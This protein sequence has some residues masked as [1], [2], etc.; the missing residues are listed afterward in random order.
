MPAG[1]THDWG[2]PVTASKPPIKYDGKVITQGTPP[3]ISWRRKPFTGLGPLKN[4]TSRFLTQHWRRCRGPEA[5]SVTPRFYVNFSECKEL[6]SQFKL[7]RKAHR[8]FSDGTGK[9]SSKVQ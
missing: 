3:P 8:Y 6:V 7:R 1:T 2:Q 4:Q 5:S 9:A